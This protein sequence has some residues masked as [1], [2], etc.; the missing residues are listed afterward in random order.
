L[1]G[2]FIL[3]VLGMMGALLLDQLRKVCREYCGD[4]CIVC[5][6]IYMI[7]SSALA[8]VFSVLHA[9]VACSCT[10]TI[11][12]GLHG[13]RFFS[14]CIGCWS[15]CSLNAASVTVVLLRVMW[16]QRQSAAAAAVDPTKAEKKETKGAAVGALF[17]VCGGFT[18]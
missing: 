3:F 15:P 11:R 14:V 2:L 1:F 5:C 16:S 12:V 18:G 17:C 9:C 4:E 7:F 8:F 10:H 6:Y 13:V